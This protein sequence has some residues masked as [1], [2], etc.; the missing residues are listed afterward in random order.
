MP[1]RRSGFDRRLANHTVRH[2]VTWHLRRNEFLLATLLVLINVLN[3]SDLIFTYLAL[4]AGFAEANPF[5]RYLFSNFSPILGGYV[6]LA[7]GLLVTLTIWLLRKYRRV[8]EG[9]LL[10][11]AIYLLIILYHLFVTLAYI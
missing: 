3:L 1:E 6:K 2:K 9:A 8:L 10:I 7:V 5:L 11:L 4:G